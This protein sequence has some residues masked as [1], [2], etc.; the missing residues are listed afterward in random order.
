ML[1]THSALRMSHQQRSVSGG[2]FSWISKTKN[3]FRTLCTDLGESG[4]SDSPSEVVPLSSTLDRKL[5]LQ[6]TYLL[7]AAKTS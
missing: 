4:G 6:L 7:T 2:Q 3:N 5:H 1:M